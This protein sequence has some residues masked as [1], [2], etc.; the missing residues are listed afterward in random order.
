MRWND[1]AARKEIVVQRAACLGVKNKLRWS[2]TQESTQLIRNLAVSTPAWAENGR[3]T[4]MFSSSEVSLF[5]DAKYAPIRISTGN[6]A[7]RMQCNYF[8]LLTTTRI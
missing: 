6:L 8:H 2:Q 7:S 4:A 3:R 1:C 5:H